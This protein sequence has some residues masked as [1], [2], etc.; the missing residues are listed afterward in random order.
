MDLTVVIRCCD[1]ERVFRCIESIDENVEIIVSLCKNSDLEEELK[2]KSIK[3]TIAPRGNLSK[4]SNRG[5]IEASYDKV[6]ITDSDTW[7][8]K[9]CINRVNE[10]LNDHKVV[11][12]GLKFERKKDNIISELIAKARDYVN[13]LPLVFTPGIG[14]RKDILPN[15]GG[16]LFN[17][18]VPFAVDADLNYRIKKSNI[19][20]CWLMDEVFIYHDS[21]FVKH[22]LKS[23]YRIGKGCRRSVEILKNHEDFS[24]IK[25]NE[26]KAVKSYHWCDIIKTKG[27]LVYAYQ[28]LWDFLYWSGYF[29]QF[30]SR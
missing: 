8:G 16:F 14:V 28:L 27:G 11:K 22:D 4:T 13:S 30:F 24:S 6:I 10:C 23:A 21:E 12:P 2:S 26:L 18:P 3:Y 25:W 1:D 29:N 15:I 19:G 20:I 9:N 7:F 5:F 17:N